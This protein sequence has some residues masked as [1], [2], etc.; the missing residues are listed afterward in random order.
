MRFNYQLIWSIL[1]QTCFEYF[2]NQFIQQEL[3][4][5]LI[6][7]E[8][9]YPNIPKLFHFKVEIRSQLEFQPIMITR[10]ITAN[11]TIEHYIN[12]IRANQSKVPEKCFRSK[13]IKITVGSEAQTQ[14]NSFV[15]NPK[16]NKTETTETTG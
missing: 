4:R 1:D 15:S 13:T 10:A 3:F 11:R 14:T 5:L 8:I 2:P 7:I 12:E 16:N 9:V 6:I